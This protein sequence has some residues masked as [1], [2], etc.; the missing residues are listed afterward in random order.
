M[1][2][3]VK[4]MMSVE[5]VVSG[6]ILINVHHICVIVKYDTY[7]N[8]CI[9]LVHKGRIITDQEGYDKILKI[10]DVE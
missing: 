4:N 3:K 7:N 10:I 2:V 1:F 6:D 8:Y 5:D 9:E